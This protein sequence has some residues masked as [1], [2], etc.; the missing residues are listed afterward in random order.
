LVAEQGWPRVSGLKLDVEGAEA[1]VLRG[2][3]KTL[4]ANPGALILVEMS[5]GSRIED[6]LETLRLLQDLGFGVR[7][8]GLG[9]EPVPVGFDDIVAALSRPHWQER[10]FNVVASRAPADRVPAAGRASE[11]MQ[12]QA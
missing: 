5:G 9:R 6:S 10:L 4:E 11:D 7:R 2:S 12:Q 3:L 8:F 1:A